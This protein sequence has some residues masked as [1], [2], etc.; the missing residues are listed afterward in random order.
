MRAGFLALVLA[1]LGLAP[2][3]ACQQG[4]AQPAPSPVI[5]VSPLIPPLP[6]QGV[7]PTPAE[8]VAAQSVFVEGL[9]RFQTGKPEEAAERFMAVASSLARPRGE[10]YWE[11]YAQNRFLAYRN[12]AIAWSVAD[13]LP[14]ARAALSGALDGD[15]ECRDGLLELLATLGPADAAAA[16]PAAVPAAAPAAVPA[17]APEAGVAAPAASGLSQ[18][19]GGEPARREGAGR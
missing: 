12:A 14:E 8:I 18:A 13:K 7:E 4:Q 9:A 19:A 3:A 10:P 11:A 6:L 15:P 1:G 16:E 17:A 5:G 2:L